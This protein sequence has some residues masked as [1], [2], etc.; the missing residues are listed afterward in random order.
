MTRWSVICLLILS[1][2]GF[3]QA[4]LVELTS[5][6]GRTMRATIDHYSPDD[7]EVAVR[8]NGEGR[9]IR[10]SRDLLNENSVK[11]LEAWYRSYAVARLLRFDIERIPGGDGNTCYY[12]IEITNPSNTEISG[13]RA[14]YQI[15]VKERYQIAKKQ[16][17]SSGG[18]KGKSK[19][20]NQKVQYETKETRSV[21]S[22]KINISKIPARG[23]LVVESEPIVIES[24]QAAASAN[25]KGKGKGKQSQGSAKPLTNRH[26]VQGILLKIYAG[27]TLLQEVESKHGLSQII[28][29]Y[30]GG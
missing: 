10:F 30:R 23:E 27:K 4:E 26:S 1:V 22:G 9:V 29:Q 16:S 24:K 8:V 17:K 19:N 7:G 2:T 21:K 6:D 14:E 5:K 13:L 25:T 20:K 11:T 18:K 15:P 12:S 28:E 3:A